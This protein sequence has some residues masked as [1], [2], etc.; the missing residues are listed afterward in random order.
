L[1]VML[2]QILWRPQVVMVIEPTVFCAPQAWLTARLSGAKAWLHI[3]DLEIDAA[4][5]LGIL[6]SSLLSR[7]IS[8]LDSWLMRRFDRVS[9]ISRGMMARLKSKGVPPERMF[10]LPNWA[11]TERMQPDYEKAKDFRRKHEIGPEDFVVLYSGNLGLKQGLEIVLEAASELK[12]ENRLLFILCGDGPAKTDL[13]TKAHQ[14]NLTN[15]RFL[16]VQPNEDLA[17]ML[18]AADVHLVIQKRGAAD[19][20][21]PSKMTNIL[22]VGGLAVITADENTELGRLVKDNPGIAVLIE[23]ES[24]DALIQTL[25]NLIS[26]GEKRGGPVAA[27][28]KYAEEHMDREAV[29]GRFHNEMERLVVQ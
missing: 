7:I 29:L 5:A 23:P 17:A 3:Q 20:V 18:S 6:P 14:K 28:R 16:P 27:A 10:F 19:L 1:P 24:S 15:V 11:D 25:R 12:D 21:M 2:G 8:G 4:F 26:P 22:A 9:T 13:E